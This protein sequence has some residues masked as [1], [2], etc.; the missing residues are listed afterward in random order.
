MKKI[1]VL[2]AKVV[3]ALFLCTTLFLSCQKGDKSASGSG[4]MGNLRNLFSRHKTET[5]AEGALDKDT[6]YAF[7]MYMANFMGGQMGMRETRFDYDS[8]MEGFKTYLEAKET[9]L[10]T[11]QAME[12]INA[13]MTQIQTKSNEKKQADGEK[14][15]KEGEAYLAQNKARSGV[16]TT[17]SGLQ[18]EVI[19]EGSGAKPA[20]SD[21]VQV[22]YEGT[23]IDGTVFDS[24]YKSGK[25][26]EFPVG[27]VIPGWAEGVQL[28][29]EGSTY[30]FVIPSELAYGANGNQSIPPNATLIFKVE[31]L[32]IVHNNNTGNTAPGSA[33]K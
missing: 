2:T 32:N 9:R 4:F 1:S 16:T 14:N 10:T 13:A 17:A 23:L 6:S 15:K 8:F 20:K 33:S 22:N 28:M 30:R 21:T 25:P 19:T 24:T 26:A 3:V 27:G 5:T 29:S 7:G 18:Y 31:L 12:K 11:D